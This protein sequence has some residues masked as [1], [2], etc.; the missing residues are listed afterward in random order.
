MDVCV[1]LRILKIDI[2]S[3]LML[4]DERV[5]KNQR[6]KLVIGDDEIDRGCPLYK[7]FCLWVMVASPEIAGDAL[8]Q[9]LR[10]SYVDDAT[11]GVSEEVAARMRRDGGWIDHG[12]MGCFYLEIF[13]AG[14]RES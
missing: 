14:P 4:L 13:A 12:S 11:G 5:F 1:T 10:L 2:V 3:R 7:D 8:F 6:L 9:V